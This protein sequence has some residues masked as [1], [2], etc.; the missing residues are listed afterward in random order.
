MPN[1]ARLRDRALHH[2]TSR[3]V[4]YPVCLDPE[5]REELRKLSETLKATADEAALKAAELATTPAAADA[6][7]TRRRTI[8]DKPAQLTVAELTEI[9]EAAMAPLRERTS[10]I[11]AKAAEDDN[12]VVVVFG[13]PAEAIG[14][15]AAYYETVAAE[16]KQRTMSAGVIMRELVERSYRYTESPAGDDL[17][18]GW[19]AVRTSVLNHADLEVLDRTVLELYREPSAIPFDPVNF[20]QPPQS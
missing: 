4:R 13:M 10:A 1:L 7:A 14:D 16:H 20:G 3:Q 11:L 15:P 6:P 17:D 5:L 2:L 9:A 12:L 8:A 19:D 18:L